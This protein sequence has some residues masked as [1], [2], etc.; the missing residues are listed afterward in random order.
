MRPFPKTMT[1]TS[2]TYLVIMSMLPVARKV[3]AQLNHLNNDLTD[4]VHAI[5]EGKG[6]TQERLDALLS[7]SAKI[8]YLQ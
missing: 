4:P 5:A 8:E 1:L 3:V 2:M 7:V 6:T